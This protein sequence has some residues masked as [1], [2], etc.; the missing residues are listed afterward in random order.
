[1]VAK[2]GINYYYGHT[3]VYLGG[4]KV[5]EVIKP[6]AKITSIKRLAWQRAYRIKA[7][8]SNST[9]I[10]KKVAEETTESLVSYISDGVVKDNNLNI[11]IKPQG[12]IIGQ[13]SKNDKVKITGK[14]GDWYRIIYKDRDAFI[15][16]KYVSDVKMV[17]IYVN[18]EK[19]KKGTLKD[20]TTF[21]N[22]NG[23]DVAVRTLF[24]SVGANVE[25]RDEK[26]QINI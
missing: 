21:I 2:P 16:S 6:R 9:P 22:I 3:G 14:Q 10:S 23:E 11:R 5:L 20:G 26:V 13:F 18:G 8:E 12:K 19:I 7:L 25:W 4:G 24:E 15:S 1:M 17:D